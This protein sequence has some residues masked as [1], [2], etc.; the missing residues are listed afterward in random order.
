MNFFRLFK[1]LLVALVVLSITS[2]S[3]SSNVA[4]SGL[5]QKRKY[6][7]GFHL[8]IANHKKQQDEKSIK[9][10]N[11]EVEVELIAKIEPPISKKSNVFKA[12]Q[13]NS[14]RPVFEQNATENEIVLENSLQPTDEALLDGNESKLQPN[15]DIQSR[16][17]ITGNYQKKGKIALLHAFLVGIFA[18]FSAFL[19]SI[20]F[21]VLGV[22]LAA[23]S[24]AAFLITLIMAF[25]STK[26]SKAARWALFVLFLSMLAAGLLIFLIIL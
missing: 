23:A 22:L 24:F 21:P 10:I 25:S 14:L 20:G 7:N 26:Y 4:D 3:T 1:T 6:R 9:P 8:N 11:R 17:T 2:C 18:V 5:I 19:F 16:K 13:K 12:L 15:P